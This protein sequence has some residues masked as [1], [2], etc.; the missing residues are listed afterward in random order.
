M[1]KISSALQQS[2]LEQL[3]A[4][5]GVTV[6]PG[7][8]LA[9]YTRFGLGGPCLALVDVS[10]V[11]SL[12][13]VPIPNSVIIGGGSNLIVAD[14]GLDQIVVR[15]TGARIERQG[16]RTLA[17]AGAL[18]QDVVDFHVAEGLAGMELMTGIPG[19]F[20]GALY[21][22]AGAYGQTIMDFVEWVE[23]FDGRTVQR[24]PREQCG[25]VYRASCFKQ[26]KDWVILRARMRLAPGDQSALAAASA[27]ILSTRNAKFPPTMKCAGSIFK[28]QIAARL[29]EGTLNRVPRELIRG[30]RI[31]SAWFLEQV[32]AKGMRNGGIQVA[33]Y[34]ANL[35]YND[36]TGSALEVCGLID[37]LKA[38]VFA[39]FGIHLEE[40]VQYVGFPSRQ[41]H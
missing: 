40:E 38:K 9:D 41:S 22:N 18:W 24:I 37:A 11:D 7:A 21:G 39:E 33:G 27:E 36:G 1:Q 34:H 26:R 13:A 5:P 4:L 20:G 8:R 14:E 30:G 17:E 29:P 2:T 23:V 31:P 10:N 15:F 6:R 19:W 35:I 3:A 12:T 16:T 25:F 32:G 28:N